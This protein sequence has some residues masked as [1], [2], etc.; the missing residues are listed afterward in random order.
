MRAMRKRWS[1]SLPSIGSLVLSVALSGFIISATEA[2]GSNRSSGPSRLVIASDARAYG[3]VTPPCVGC[4]KLPRNF[5]PLSRT[6]SR[7]VSLGPP[8]SRAPVG[9]WCFILNHGINPSTATAVGSVVKVEGSGTRQFSFETVQWVLGAPNCSPDQIEF[10]TVGY[11]IESAH[12]TAVPSSRI[13]FS[14]MVD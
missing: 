3:L 7:N 9:T 2:T 1:G 13:S 12:I 4:A 6:H 14:F 8:L 11:I 10:Q 5:S